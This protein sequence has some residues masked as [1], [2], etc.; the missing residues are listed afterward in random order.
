LSRASVASR[1]VPQPPSGTV[2]FL[3][4][5]I[6]GSTRLWEDDADAMREALGRHD[7]ILRDVIGAGGGF[8][9]ATGGDGFAVAFARAGDAVAAAKTAQMSLPEPVTT[10]RPCARST[11]SRRTFPCSSRRSSGAPTS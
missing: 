5:D 1:L 4:T 11:C 6:E 7:E 10:S 3:F 9:F 8:V 2:T